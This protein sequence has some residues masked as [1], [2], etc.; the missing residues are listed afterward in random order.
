ML[1]GDYVALLHVVY[2]LPSFFWCG[3]IGTIRPDEPVRIP[4]VPNNGGV[5]LRVRS[6]CPIHSG[7]GAV[8]PDAEPRRTA[9][10]TCAARPRVRSGRLEGPQ[11]EQVRAASASSGR[12][13]SIGAALSAA[14]QPG[15]WMRFC[16]CSPDR[17]T[18][19]RQRIKASK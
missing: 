13:F 15:V 16:S 8:R 3:G 1:R 10:P 14:N 2:E 18:D 4:F 9:L 12:L 17:K 5:P 7:E 6:V 19:N 11:E